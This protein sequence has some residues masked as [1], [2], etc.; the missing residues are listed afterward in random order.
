MN[1]GERI[2]ALRFW[3]FKDPNEFTAKSRNRNLFNDYI[4][5]SLVDTLLS[6]SKSSIILNKES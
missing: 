2:V 6:R 5:G 4:F 1:F 3:K